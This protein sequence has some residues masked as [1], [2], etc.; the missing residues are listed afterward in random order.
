MSDLFAICRFDKQVQVGAGH[1]RVS[2]QLLPDYKYEHF[3]GSHL[4][5]YTHTASES[6]PILSCEPHGGMAI[7]SRRFVVMR[8]T[9]TARYSCDC[10]GQRHMGNSER[11]KTSAVL[12]KMHQM[13][14]RGV[15]S[16]MSPKLPPDRSLLRMPHHGGPIDAHIGRFHATH[17]NGIST[18]P[19]GQAVLHGY[20]KYDRGM[21]SPL[22][23][24]PSPPAF[25]FK[26]S[27]VLTTRFPAHVPHYDSFSH[28]NC[29]FCRISDLHIVSS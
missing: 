26:F 25:L 14:T 9:T 11:V 10:T 29:I 5:F 4:H 16:V 22:V 7:F 21:A 28:Y 18:T 23:S 20:L 19:R 1:F 3:Q 12:K 24:T 27:L 2:G 6:H 15:E 13:T 17:R 8:T